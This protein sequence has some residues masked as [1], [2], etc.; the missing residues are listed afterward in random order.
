MTLGTTS[1]AMGTT[2]T[3]ASPTASPSPRPRRSRR[4]RGRRRSQRC[5][6]ALWVGATLPIWFETAY[7]AAPEAGQD[8]HAQDDS[9]NDPGPRCQVAALMTTSTSASGDDSPL[10]SSVRGSW[11]TFRSSVPHGVGETGG[12]ADADSERWRRTRAD[13]GASSPAAGTNRTGGASTPWSRAL[14]SGWFEAGRCR[15]SCRRS[16]PEHRRHR[17][18]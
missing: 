17:V 1:A 2:W 15:A 11:A 3:P 13:A 9:T 16:Q 10:K 5:L 12:V 6:R 7:P 8:S 18:A 14:P 4:R